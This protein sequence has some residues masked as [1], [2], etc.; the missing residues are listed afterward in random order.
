V[1]EEPEAVRLLRVHPVLSG[2]GASFA[3][4]RERQPVQPAPRRLHWYV[5]FCRSHI[6]FGIFFWREYL[7]FG[8]IYILKNNLF[9]HKHFS[10]FIQLTLG[11]K[12]LN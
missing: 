12:I 3:R 8:H 9:R 10:S 1:Q 7:F 2:P 5:F 11:S 6:L 4:R